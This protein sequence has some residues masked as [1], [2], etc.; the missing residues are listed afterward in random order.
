MRNRIAYFIFVAI[1]GALAYVGLQTD[2]KSFVGSLFAAFVS[3]F[4]V[5]FVEMEL[6]PQISIVQ[7]ATPPV[8]PDGRK[9][10]RVVVTNRALWWPLKLIMDRRPANQVRAWITFLTESNHPVFAPQR[11]MIGRWSTTPEPVRPIMISQDPGR[12]PGMTLL[13]DLSVTRDA[14]DIGA[15]ANELLDIVMR[16][17]GENGCRGCDKDGAPAIGQAAY[18]SR[19]NPIS[20]S[21]LRDE[22]RLFRS[23]LSLA[24]RKALTLLIASARASGLL[25]SVGECPSGGSLTFVRTRSGRLG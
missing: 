2:H 20:R 9:F 10:L 5:L 12:A 18:H 13:L 19:R 3:V 25:P 11:Q 7:E 24:A 14:I 6:R 16:T 8:L 21:A 22:H 1:L 15:G 17:P 23:Y 4:V